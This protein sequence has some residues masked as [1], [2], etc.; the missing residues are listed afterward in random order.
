MSLMPSL[1]ATIVYG[2]VNWPSTSSVPSLNERWIALHHCK[3]RQ[4]QRNNGS[5]ASEG[6]EEREGDGGDQGWPCHAPMRSYGM[7]HEWPWRSQVRGVR[8]R[9]RL[10]KVRAVRTPGSHVILL[11]PAP[12]SIPIRHRQRPRDRALPFPTPSRSAPVVHGQDID[13]GRHGQHALAPRPGPSSLYVL[14]ITITSAPPQH[15]TAS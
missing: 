6:C 5:I 7:L 3:R 4:R 2:V 14:P 11:P 8:T 12:T 9:R 10:S 13:R 1:P 15:V